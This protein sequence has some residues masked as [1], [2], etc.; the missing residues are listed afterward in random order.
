MCEVFLREAMLL[1]ECRGM[2][3]VNSGIAS[4][5]MDVALHM[6]GCFERRCFYKEDTRS[7]NREE[8]TS[9]ET[10]A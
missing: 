9:E 3:S 1:F 8:R 7:D 5:E 6:Y 2:N 10:I 4:S